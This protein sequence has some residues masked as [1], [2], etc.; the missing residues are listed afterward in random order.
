MDYLEAA[1]KERRNIHMT[2]WFLYSL[3]IYFLVT[4]DHTIL[5]MIA[6]ALLV[7]DFCIIVSTAALRVNKRG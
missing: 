6:T 5:A 4:Y 2:K 1:K 3:A 7:G